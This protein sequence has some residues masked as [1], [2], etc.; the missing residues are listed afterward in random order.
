MREFEM[1]RRSYI[2][3]LN[4][5]F[6]ANCRLYEQER[7]GHILV[8]CFAALDYEDPDPTYLDA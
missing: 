1:H 6:A 5:N 3:K 4:C 2:Y 7:G 8:Y